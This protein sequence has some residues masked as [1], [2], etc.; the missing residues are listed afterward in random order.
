MNHKFWQSLPADIRSTLEKC[1]KDATIKNNEEAE[2]MNMQALQR[3]KQEP[4]TM[5]HELSPEERKL[6][7]DALAPVQRKMEGR[8]SRDLINQVRQIARNYPSE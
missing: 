4:N 1:I 5:V 6:W 3:V 8:I 2:K 7:R